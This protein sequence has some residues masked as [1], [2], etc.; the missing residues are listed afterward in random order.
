MMKACERVTFSN[1]RGNYC[2]NGVQKG[3]ALVLVRELHHKEFCRVLPG[4]LPCKQPFDI[5]LYCWKQHLRKFSY[6]PLLI[7]SQ[8]YAS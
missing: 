5:S 6:D 4:S 3:K 1:E 7:N 8:R 2:Q